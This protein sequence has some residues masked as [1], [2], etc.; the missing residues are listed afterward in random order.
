MFVFNPKATRQPYPSALK[1]VMDIARA[2]QSR[3]W[4]A[5]WPRLNPGATPLYPLPGLAEQLGVAQLLVKDESVRSP[6][7]SFKA[8]GAPIAL[9]RLIL[10]SFPE[11]GFDPQ[12][13][14][15]GRYA[16]AL[17]DFTVIS[18]TDGNHGKGLAAA[19]Q[20][21]G[22]RCVI[23]LHA[24]VSAEREQAI[25]DYGARIVRISGNY[26][27]SVAHAAQLAANNGWTVVSDTSYA[28]YEVIPRDVMQG[29]GTI[30]AEI[31]EASAPTHVFLQGGVGG[32]AAGIV[33]YLWEL[34]GQQRP[35]FVMVEPEQADCLLQSAV[36][37]RAARAT[38]SVDS[39]MAGLACGETSPLAWRFLE[40]SVDG[41][42]TI[43][44]AQAVAAMRRLAAGSARDVPL[45]AG[46][47]GVAGLAGLV[48]LM[49]DA[50][51]AARLGLDG[52][53]R[54]LFINTEGATAPG[55]YAELV[56]ETAAS[57]LGRQQVWLAKG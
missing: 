33:S 57:V 35:R 29:Y 31:A 53:A 47:S 25:A 34:H 14:L 51:Q 20:S 45:L 5:T 3:Q 39:V 23:V 4:L 37:G 54:V 6:L 2:E 46:E 52:N 50:E 9:V 18:A 15:Q 44:D 48:A 24:Q 36:Q 40:T 49:Q 26:D 43:S 13:L 32:L 7:G 12:G 19:A 55:V 21:V 8:L 1:D 30:A 41:F 22:C 10:R 16:Q 11:Q 42:M 56:G 27:A 38:G 17:A 28:G